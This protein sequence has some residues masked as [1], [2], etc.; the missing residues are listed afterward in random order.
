MVALCHYHDSYTLNAVTFPSFP[1][2]TQRRV[3]QFFDASA[4]RPLIAWIVEIGDEFNPATDGKITGWLSKCPSLSTLTILTPPSSQ[5][6]RTF[7]SIE[8]KQ[9]TCVNRKNKRLSL[10]VDWFQ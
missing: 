6:K 3:T 9:L 1:P 4:L 2:A 5:P 8:C 10:V 7:W